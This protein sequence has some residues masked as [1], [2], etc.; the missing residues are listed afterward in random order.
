MF[1]KFYHAGA[2]LRMYIEMTWGTF[3]K[4]VDKKE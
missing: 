3:Q 2:Q 1:V 4:H